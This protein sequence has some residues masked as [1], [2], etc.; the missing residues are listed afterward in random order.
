ML[1]SPAA[2]AEAEPRIHPH[3]LAL[4]QL[5]VAASIGWMAA[6]DVMVCSP[7]EVHVDGLGLETLDAKMLDLVA[8]CLDGCL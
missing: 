1:S 6:A 5:S 3:T 8:T 7:N 2:G 4:L